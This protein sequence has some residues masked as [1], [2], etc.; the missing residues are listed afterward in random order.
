MLTQNHEVV[1]NEMGNIRV[2]LVD[3]TLK[4]IVEFAFSTAT[5]KDLS[6]YDRAITFGARISNGRHVAQNNILNDLNAS[7]AS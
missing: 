4:T 2:N 5:S 3:A 6:L 7:A 1:V